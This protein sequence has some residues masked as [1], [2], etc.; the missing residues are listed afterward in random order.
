MSGFSCW[1]NAE[2]LRHCEL[3]LGYL[4]GILEVIKV[5]L[6]HF[7]MGQGIDHPLFHK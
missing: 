6:S 3:P 2:F 4:E 5:S 7:I 1:G